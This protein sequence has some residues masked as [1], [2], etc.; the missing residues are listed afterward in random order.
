MPA[1]VSGLFRYPVKSMQGMTVERLRFD[2]C[3]A[4]GDRRYAV[5]DAATDRIISA[6]TEPRLLEASAQDAAGGVTLRLPDGAELAAD[7]PAVDDTLSRWLGR[8][9]TLAEADVEPDRA[10]VYDARSRSYEMT[11]DPAD[12]A[13]EAYAIPSPSGT[14]LDL[15]AAHVL[16]TA[17]I[18]RCREQ[19]PG[20]TWDVR[21]FRPNVLVELDGDGFPEDDWVGRQVRLGGAVLAVDQRAVRCAMP[22]RAQPGGIDRDLAV[23]HT[24]QELHDN[25]LGVYCRVTT[26]GEVRLGDA[27]ELEPEPEPDHVPP[28]A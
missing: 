5:I 28:E 22:L 10:L 9:V 26:P 15:A 2:V 21:R 17:S 23:F 16:T 25:H 20:T 8:P 18:A 24:M 27:V 13:A 4:V 1:T 7:D 6:K 19:A 14:F 12:D 11:F 3:G